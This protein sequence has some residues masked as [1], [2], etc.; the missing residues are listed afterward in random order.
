[1]GFDRK[2]HSEL[3]CWLVAIYKPWPSEGGQIP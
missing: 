3:R 1:M 2:L